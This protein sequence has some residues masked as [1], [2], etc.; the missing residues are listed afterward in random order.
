MQMKTLEKIEARRLRRE[1][2]LTVDEIAQK[3]QISKSSVSRWIQDISLPSKIVHR[4]KMAGGIASGKIRGEKSRKI[5]Q[6]YQQQGSRIAEQYGQDPLFVAGCMMHW[7]EGTK[8]R[9]SVQICNTDPY[10][11]RLWLKF[12][13]TFFDVPTDSI[14]IKVSCYLNNGKTQRQIEDH[15]LAELN[16]PRSCLTKTTLIN[17][18]P[19]SSG[20]KTNRHPC[21]IARIYIGST[22]IVQQI[23]GAIKALA[24]IDDN[25]QWLN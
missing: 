5:R 24:N 22:K 12:I 14:R 2:Q 23:W 3:L 18:H 21:G 25:N 17:K 20:I 7:S 11:L 9:N 13:Q 10:F 1:R 4:R 6:S 16:L 19:M 15:W 8:N